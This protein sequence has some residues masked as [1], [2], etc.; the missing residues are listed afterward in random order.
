[1]AAQTPFTTHATPAPGLGGLRALQVGVVYNPRSHRNRKLAREVDAVPGVHVAAPT[2]RSELR[3]LLADFA[4]KGVTCLVISGG[5]GTVRDVLTAG[6]PVFGADWPEIAVIPA[7]KTNALNFDLGSPKDWS[8][9]GVL[10]AVEHGN[11]VIRR[12]LVVRDVEGGGELAGFV[13]G[14][15]IFTTAI[16]AG[17]D[18]HRLGAFDSLAVASTAVWGVVQMFLGSDRNRWRR[19]VAMDIRVGDDRA[20]LPR[21]VWG[22]PARRT[23]LLAASLERFP[24]GTKPFGSIEGMKV[25]VLDH[26]RRRVIAALPALAAGW[27]GDWLESNGIHRMPTDRIE[28]TL[29]DRFILDGEAFPAGRYAIAPGPALSFV[30]P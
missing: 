21:S 1:M 22:D 24:A 11:R 14:A 18:A 23:L 17:Q 9:S 25:A 30:V 20:P 12:P 26:P 8:L 5:D 2:R 28:L 29:G 15:G 3:P 4:A 7:G 27:E 6:L 16:A 13:L 19:G 10:D